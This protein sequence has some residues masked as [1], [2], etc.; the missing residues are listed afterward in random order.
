MACDFGNCR[1]F[2]VG[3]FWRRE[4]LLNNLQRASL[5]SHDFGVISIGSDHFTVTAP[6]L[7][8]TW[9]ITALVLQRWD[10]IVS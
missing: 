6:I 5:V 10:G 7:T 1:I 2:C 4:Q 3:E 8:P 9:D